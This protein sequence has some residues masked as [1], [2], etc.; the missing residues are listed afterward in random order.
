MKV[1]TKNEFIQKYGEMSMFDTQDVLMRIASNLSD[2]HLDKKMFSE[3]QMDQKL[4][5]MKTYIFDYI[6]V[7]RTEKQNALEMEEFNAHLGKY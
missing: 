4:N 7:M 3:E 1:M 5:V 2:M 6:S